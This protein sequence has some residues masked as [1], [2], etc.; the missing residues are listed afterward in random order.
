MAAN[1]VPIMILNGNFIPG[2]IAAANTASD[3]SG[4]LVIVVTGGTEGSR[5]DGIRFTNSSTSASTATA[6][7]F[8]IFLS[9][10]SGANFKIIGEV[11]AAAVTRSNTV[12]GQTAIYTFDQAIIMQSGQIISVCQSVYTTAADQTDAIAFAGNY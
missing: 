9:D 10:T 6:K 7:V 11:I 4:A 12:A 8:K 5:V 3:G 1:T 2:R